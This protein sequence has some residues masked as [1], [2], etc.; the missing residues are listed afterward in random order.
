MRGSRKTQA[1]RISRNPF[2]FFL[3]VSFSLYLVVAYMVSLNFFLSEGYRMMKVWWSRQDCI[4]L[5][6]WCHWQKVTCKLEQVPWCFQ[7]PSAWL[8]TCHVW[9]LLRA[10]VRRVKAVLGKLQSLQSPFRCPLPACT[11]VQAMSP[12]WASFPYL[13]IKTPLYSSASPLNPF[14]S[15]PSC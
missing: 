1:S 9:G 14:V 4:V 15:P 6:R 11:L 13:P 2:F 7:L 12:T 5:C 8:S 3:N 10:P